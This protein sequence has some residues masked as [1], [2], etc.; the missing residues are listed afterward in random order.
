MKRYK[1][2]EVLDFFNGKTRPLESGIYPL[3][4]GNG[5]IDYVSKYNY[6]NNII[7]GRVGANCGNIHECPSKCWVSDNAI[8]ASVKPNFDKLCVFYLLKALNL[9]KA[10]IGSAQPLI[11]QGILSQIEINLPD[12]NSQRKIAAV[13]KAIDDKIALNDKIN[14]LLERLARA[15]YDYYFVQFDFKDE[16]GKPYKS[17]GGAMIFNPTLNRPIPA[18]FEVLFLK[19]RLAF[20]RG[21]EYGT[22]AYIE[23]KQDE[24]CIKFYRVGDMDDLGN[25]YINQTLFECPKVSE[26]DLLVS[27]DGSVGRIAYA[28]NGTFSSGIRKIYDKKGILNSATLY[29]VFSDFFEIM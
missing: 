23:G 27:F 3:Y 5:I 26:N 28:L 8:S 11:T 2:G 19:D 29:F 12:I 25:T 21:E 6:E 7:I 17:S 20:E 16:R 22:A 15:V 14:A 24:N 10:D 13:L 1:L 4:G 9:N 18:T